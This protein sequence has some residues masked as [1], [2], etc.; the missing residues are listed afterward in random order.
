[1]I[2]GASVGIGRGYAIRFAQHD[3]AALALLDGDKDALRLLD[4]DLQD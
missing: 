1:M 4:E 3:A 2:T